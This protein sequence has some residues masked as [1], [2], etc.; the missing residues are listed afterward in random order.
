MSLY[1][2]FFQKKESLWINEIF[3]T[4]LAFWLGYSSIYAK[5]LQNLQTDFCQ[6]F[7]AKNGGNFAIKQ[8]VI[9]QPRSRD[10]EIDELFVFK[11]KL[12]IEIIN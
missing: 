4:I 1:H 7:C 2:E 10:L 9:K 6:R 11:S 5:V 8:E 12:V 3:T